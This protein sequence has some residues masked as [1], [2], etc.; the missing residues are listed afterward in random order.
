MPAVFNCVAALAALI[1]LASPA[2]VLPTLSGNRFLSGA[3][4]RLYAPG[5]QL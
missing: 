5:P 1:A 4:Q 3:E 2:L